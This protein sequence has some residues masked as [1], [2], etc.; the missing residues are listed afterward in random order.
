[1]KQTLL[2]KMKDEG[3]LEEVEE[4]SISDFLAG[5]LVT[6]GFSFIL[7]V[8]LIASW[9]TDLLSFIFF[10]TLI[11]GSIIYSCFALNEQK[12]LVWNLKKRF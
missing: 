12:R 5:S 10:A 6:F 7:G 3:I 1:M 11:F 9:G 2:Q 4:I 8:P